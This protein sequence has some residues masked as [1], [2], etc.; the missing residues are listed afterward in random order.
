MKF[1]TVSRLLMVILLSSKTFP[2]LLKHS[3]KWAEKFFPFMIQE[4]DGILINKLEWDNQFLHV[5]MKTLILEPHGCWEVWHS[6]RVDLLLTSIS[7][8]PETLQIHSEASVY[9]LFMIEKI[10][11]EKSRFM[12]ISPLSQKVTFKETK[13]PNSRQTV[14]LDQFWFLWELSEEAMMMEPSLLVPLS[15]LLSV[16]FW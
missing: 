3:M 6:E 16:V 1:L 14:I 12:T 4:K 11:S 15:P 9:W 8:S 5:S 2:L 7:L 10:W 13:M